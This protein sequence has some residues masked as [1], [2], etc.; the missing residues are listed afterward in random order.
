MKLLPQLQSCMARPVLHKKRYLKLREKR[1]GTPHYL[2]IN[3][4]LCFVI[5]L[6]SFIIILLRTQGFGLIIRPSPLVGG[7]WAW[8]YLSIWRASRLP[9]KWMWQAVSLASF[10]LHNM[11]K[12][13]MHTR[14]FVPSCAHVLTCCSHAAHMCSHA[15]HMPLTCCSHATHMLLTCTHMLLTCAT[16]MYSALT[17]AHMQHAYCSCRFCKGSMTLVV[18]L[19]VNCRPINQPKSCRYSVVGFLAPISP[20]VV[21][22]VGWQTV[23]LVAG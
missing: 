21:V 22:S 1:V 19:S 18:S 3:T 11:Q 13:L 2:A 16:C 4:A 23:T 14:Q 8:D 17:A 7:I 6:V 20:C 15:A 10:L 9:C 5:S 12:I